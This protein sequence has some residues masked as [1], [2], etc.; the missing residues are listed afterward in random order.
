MFSLPLIFTPKSVVLFSLSINV[1]NI[2]LSTS[3][4]EVVS[5]W[6]FSIFDLKYLFKNHLNVLSTSTLSFDRTSLSSEEQVKLIIISITSNIQIF[7]SKK[8]TLSSGLER[9]IRTIPAWPP[10]SRDFCHFSIISK[11]QCWLFHLFGNY[12]IVLMSFFAISTESSLVSERT[13]KTESW[14]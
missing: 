3:D 14:I 13:F 4:L 2:F 9:S 8:C 10:T 6:H 12:N 5:Q 1:S 7:C 11:T